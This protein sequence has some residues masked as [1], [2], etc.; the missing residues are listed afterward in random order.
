MNPH[1]LLID[2]RID[3]R[4]SSGCIRER[5]GED[6][7][8]VPDLDLIFVLEN[9]F[10]FDFDPVHLRAGSRCSLFAYYFPSK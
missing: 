4:G 2:L 3:G 1:K 6:E 5:L 8:A 7:G 10:F 9:V